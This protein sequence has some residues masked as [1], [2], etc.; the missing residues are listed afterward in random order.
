MDDLGKGDIIRKISLDILCE[1][2]DSVKKLS[3]K[4]GWSD[5]YTRKLLEY[6]RICFMKKRW[7]TENRVLKEYRAG[8]NKKEIAES[9]GLS[10]STVSKVYLR[11]N[12]PRN[13]KGR[14]KGSKR[15]PS[16]DKMIERGLSCKDIAKAEGLNAEGWGV[17]LYMKATGQHE[18]WKDKRQ[19]LKSDSIAKEQ[20]ISCMLNSLVCHKF[21]EESNNKLAAKRVIEYKLEHPMNQHPAEEIYLPV[22]R[23]CEALEKGEKHSLEKLCSG[24]RISIISLSRIFR[25]MNLVP[26][27][28]IAKKVYEAKEAGF[29]DNEITELLDIPLKFVNYAKA[30]KT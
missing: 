27:Y 29:Q 23:Y 20:I 15:I 21:I 1:G 19:E 18:K 2:I 11:L 17:I 30:Q 13:K 25:K 4:E 8:K 22:S 12:L 5:K 14:P 3:E 6:A 7:R 28:R 9:T 24:T 10:N 16:R 26:M